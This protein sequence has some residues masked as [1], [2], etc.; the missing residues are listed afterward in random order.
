MLALLLMRERDLRAGPRAARAGKQV[1]AGLRH[2]SGRPDLLM[3][4]GMAA[5]SDPRVALAVG[6]TTSV[7]AAVG[8][9]A[10]RRRIAARG[11][12]GSAEGA[13]VEA[14]LES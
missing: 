3:P 7:L 6:G 9:I 14:R 8:A 1:R 12:P 5:A 13:T 4:I 10:W 2:V 11:G